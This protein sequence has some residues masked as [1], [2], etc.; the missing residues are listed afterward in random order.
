VNGNNLSNSNMDE[1]SRAN[2]ENELLKRENDQLK[3]E[4]E[5][6]RRENDQ[7]KRDIEK[8]K[9]DAEQERKTSREL[10]SLEAPRIR[11]EI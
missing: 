6:L 8:I 2:R 3:R 11:K 7:S 9:L 10:L 5:Q 1:I 4:N